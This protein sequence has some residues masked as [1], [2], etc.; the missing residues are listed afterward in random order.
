MRKLKLSLVG[1]FTFA[2]LLPA[3]PT[4][5]LPEI[6]TISASGDILV[7]N[8]L[9]DRA[10]TPGGYNFYPLIRRI[11]PHL[12]NTVD[13]CHL[14]TPLTS[15]TPSNYPVFATPFQL[16]KGL[17]QIGFEGCSLASNHTIDRG[18]TGIVD[19]RK[20]LGKVGLKSAGAR[21]TE[22]ESGLAWYQTP[23]GNNIAQLS[24]TYSYNG[25]RL[26]A[27][28]EWRSN[29]INV[30]AIKKAAR[31]ARLAGAELVVLSIHWGAEYQSTLTSVQVA[32]AT[33]LMA[34]P[35][36]DALIGHHAH[37][38]QPAVE[39]NGKPVLYG[40]GN[41]WSGQGPWAGMPTGN[42]GVIAKLQFEINSS[43]SQF[44]G[45]TYVPTHTQYKTWVIQ[46]AQ[47]ISKVNAEACQSIK[48]A[49][50]LLGDL[51]DGPTT[52]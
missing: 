29:L 31:T 43:G 16:A 34:S 20:F 44:V 42:H 38:L 23:A 47:K 39:M 7:H 33:K 40:L 12:Q 48:S 45:G 52:C 5:A 1:L 8:T 26:P 50:K 51:L 2:L 19:T 35:N 46:P 11:S 18:V 6:I 15:K 49:A 13:I 21:L 27:G 24:Y 28:E 41:L 32:M 17:R 30:P 22:A 37:V 25:F 3:Q 4:S 9:Y 10:K 36:I 14:E